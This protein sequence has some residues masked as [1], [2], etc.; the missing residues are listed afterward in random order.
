MTDSRFSDRLLLYLLEHFSYYCV[1][2]ASGFVRLFL[3]KS[4]VGNQA[5][6]NTYRKNAL[7]RVPQV[8]AARAL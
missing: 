7:E 2:S 3:T 6:V 5:P 4:R 8:R 1:L